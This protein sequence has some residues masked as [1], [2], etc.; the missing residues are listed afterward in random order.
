VVVVA[1]RWQVQVSQTGIGPV[2][3]GQAV[4]VSQL[5]VDVATADDQIHAFR[6]HG[7]PCSMLHRSTVHLITQ[8]NGTVSSMRRAATGFIP[9]G[10]VTR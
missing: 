2:A 6:C 7:S 8:R 5:P 1:V 10:R 3:G 4:R 9:T